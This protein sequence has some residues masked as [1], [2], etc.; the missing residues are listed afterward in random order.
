MIKSKSKRI[1]ATPTSFAKQHYLFVQE[2]GSLESVS[3]HI[4]QRENIKSFLF[5]IVTSGIGSLTYEDYTYTLSEGDCVWIDCLKPYAHES[6]VTNPWTLMWVHFY[7]TEAPAFFNIFLNQGNKVIFH[8]DTPSHFT[9]SLTLLYQAHTTQHVFMELMAHKY[10]T[11]IITFSFTES[12]S[13]FSHT[14]GITSKLK[15]VHDFIEKHYQDKLSLEQLS[16][17]FFISKFHLS[18]EYKKTYGITIGNDILAKRI[19]N[20][21]SLLRFSDSS[22]EE[23]AVTCGF[24]DGTYFIKVFKYSE[25]MTPLEYRKHW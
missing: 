1:L 25:N 23:I 18:R 21:K 11:D 8:P 10:L 19:S 20:A 2:V 7:G 16:A 15:Q 22:I 3:P 14:E 12:K 5:F 4:S 9:Q 24:L 17:T 13:A 6:S